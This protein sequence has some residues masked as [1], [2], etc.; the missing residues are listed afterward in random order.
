MSDRADSLL[1][2]P[3][4]PCSSTPMPKTSTRV[5]CTVCLGAKIV[6]ST[7]RIRIVNSDEDRLVCSSGHSAFS[8]MARKSAVGSREWVNTQQGMA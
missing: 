1:P 7:R 2:T 8:A 6:E 3:L 4:S 5:P